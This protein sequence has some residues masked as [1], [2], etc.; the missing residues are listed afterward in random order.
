MTYLGP[1]SGELHEKVWGEE[2]WIINN[3][4]YCFKILVLKP[5]FQCSLH[6]HLQKRETFVV[7]AGLV[8]LE[9]CDVRGKHFEETLISGDQRTIQ[10]KTLHR[11]SSENGAVIYEISTTH[12][13]FDVER[14]EESKAIESSKDSL[15]AG[16]S[17][18][19]RS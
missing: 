6:R 8:K 15:L 10:P 11:F 7:Y 17:W 3:E 9:Q 16:P 5:G 2:I 4:D 19:N 12:S 13:D 1:L 18:R 14:L